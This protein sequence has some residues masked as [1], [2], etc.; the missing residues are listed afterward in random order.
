MYKLFAI[1][2]TFFI[3][4]NSYSESLSLNNDSLNSSLSSKSF[5]SLFDLEESPLTAEEAFNI[6]YNIKNKNLS[7]NINIEPEH[8][9]YLHKTK[10]LINGKI[11]DFEFNNY[12][13]KIDEHYGE[14]KAIY[15]TFNISV[16]SEEEIKEFEFEYQGCSEKFNICYP[17]QT[18]KKK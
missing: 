2:L 10:L 5:G 15:S 1:L 7:I 12:V 17:M 13:N 4:F 11:K 9:L 8:Y 18:L 16:N 6:N 3:A 14:I